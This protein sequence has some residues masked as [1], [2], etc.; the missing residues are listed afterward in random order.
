MNKKKLLFLVIVVAI[1]FSATGCSIPTDENGKFVLI[2][3]DTTFGYMVQNEGFFAAIF[4]YPLSQLINWFAS[5]NMNIG[6]AIVIV[7]VL[8]NGLIL[9]FTLKQNIQM[10]KM[11]TMQPEL[12]KITRKYE[13]KTDERSKMRQG[14][15]IQALYQKYEINPFSSII[16]MFIQF[17]ILIAMY[18]AVQRAAAVANGKFFGLSLELTPW[19][20]VKEGQFAFA[21]FYALMLIAQTA[22]MMLPQY[23]AKR[24]AKMEAEK[25]HKT[26][27]PAKNPMGNTM[28][29]MIIFIGIIGVTWPT[30]M[31]LYWMISSCVQVVKA[32]IVDQ[33]TA[34]EKKD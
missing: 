9:L 10:Q 32:I 23:L 31:S 18:Q 3:L 25:H 27:R 19:Q 21:L 24:R 14:Q 7:A 34:K 17:P 8:I 15:E 33:I 16:T 1:L 12:E 28:Y 30:A 13:G 20:G 6:L 29:F 26:Y 11:Q 22:A 2:S 5:K 4:V